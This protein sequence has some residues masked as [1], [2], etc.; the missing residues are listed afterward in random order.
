MPRRA[1]VS[2]TAPDAVAQAL[3]ARGFDVEVAADPGGVA[4]LAGRGGQPVDAYVQLP[5]AVAARGASAVERVRGFLTDGLM[6]RFDSAGA[7]LSA[8]ADDAAVVLVGGN[9]PATTGAPDDPEARLALLRVLAHTL[10]LERAGGGLR[11]VVLE[12]AGDPASVAAHAAD[13]GG[14][15]LQV[16]RAAAGPPRDLDASDW[17]DE[18]MA[19]RVLEA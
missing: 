10:L 14:R 17:R 4:A 5:V 15:P 6:A 12:A 8:L 16:V 19:L 1:I 2:G 18:L 7:V 11:I 3:Q 13:P 9:A